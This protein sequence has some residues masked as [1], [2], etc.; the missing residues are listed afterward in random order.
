VIILVGCSVVRLFIFIFFVLFCILYNFFQ[1]YRYWK[2]KKKKMKK[3]KKKEI[4]TSGS[5]HA[6]P[7]QVACELPHSFFITKRVIHVIILLVMT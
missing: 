4:P 3:K 6:P 2:K 7:L 1:N 5:D